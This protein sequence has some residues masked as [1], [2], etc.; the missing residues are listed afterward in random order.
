MSTI[1]SNS[2]ASI[3]RFRVKKLIK[4]LEAARGAGTSFI[5][6]D[7]KAAIIYFFN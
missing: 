7:D 4:T 2:D 6:I 5:R 3:E 1:I